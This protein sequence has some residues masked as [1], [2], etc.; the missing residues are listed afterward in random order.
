MMNTKITFMCHAMTSHIGKFLC[1]CSVI[2]AVGCTGN[3]TA[4][5]MVSAK[6]QLE[7]NDSQAAVIQLKNVLQKDPNLA[8]ARYLLGVTLLGLGDPV[9]AGV[10]LSK[11]QD[12]GFG[13]DKV[14]P[15]LAKSLF[16]QGQN[17]KI[18]VQYATTKLQLASAQADLLSIVANAYLALGKTKESQI[19][20]DEALRI[21]PGNIK[22][23]LLQIRKQAFLRDFDGANDRL[24]QLLASNPR[25]SEAWLVRGE[26]LLQSGKQEE[27]LAAYRKAIVFDNLNI[28]TH[29]A[30]MWILLSKKDMAAVDEQ[31]K[32][33]RATLP[34][35]PQIKFFAAMVSLEKGDIKSAY[36]Q[37]QLLLKMAPESLQALQLAGT[38]D[39]RRGANR[40]AEVN[41]T[42][43]LNISPGH[44]G[45]RLLLAQVNL[46]TG[47][48][49]KAIKALQL[50]VDAPEP[51]WEP[52]ALM[53][54]ALLMQGETAQ[55]ELY[56]M[57]AAKLN[58][59]DYRSRIAL[60]MGL[61]AKGKTEQGLS[62]LRAISALDR[63]ATADLAEINF[64]LRKKNVSSALKAI[65]NLAQKLPNSPMPVNLRGEIE[66][67]QGHKD[68][69][70]AAFTSALKIDP[71]YFPASAGIA[72]LDTAQGR[73]ELAIARFEKLSEAEPVN[74]R[75]VMALFELRVRT[76]AS[77]KDLSELLNKSI[78]SN[79]DEAGPRLALVNI[80]LAAGEKKLALAAVQDAVAAMPDNADLIEALARIQVIDGDSN[81]ALITYTKLA[82]QIPNSPKA[83]MGMA[84]IYL[85]RGNPSAA[86]Q[87]L[88][89]A[90]S[91]KSDFLPA[92]LGLVLAELAAGHGQEA[93]AVAKL[94]QTQ[95]AAET[96]G[97]ELEGNIQ[98]NLKNWA[99]AIKSYQF[100]LEKAPQT[101]TA[102]KVHK[103]YVAAG[104]AAEAKRFETEWMR[105]HG[106]DIQF[107]THLAD[108]AMVKSDFYL[109]K[110]QYEAIVKMQPENAVALN[111]I[112]WILN[113]DK[114]PIA[115]NYSLRA[116][117]LSPKNP[118]IMDTLADSY[119]NSGE[120]G[121]A[122]EIQKE[123]VALAPNAYDFRLSLARFYIAA[124][125]KRNAK[126]ELIWLEKL[127]EKL[128]NQEEIARLLS[129]LQ[130]D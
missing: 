93:V 69:A 128:P 112:A 94:V 77:R 13:A 45:I 81:Q 22:A 105:Q 40:L 80:L 24:D 53:G 97:Y 54:Q 78:K 111:N 86:V 102:V 122:I 130:F 99:A 26:V 92:Q 49:G 1:V 85:D 55:A 116:V 34:K 126:S 75:A 19:A 25:S 37:S 84:K 41:L 66:M 104:R 28:A 124:G 51:Q 14:V 31:L 90:L 11:A 38:V 125:E 6:R 18:I 44:G 52:N 118:A 72:A 15:L 2:F 35:S 58:P 129:S 43:A 113:K 16:A 23:S 29:S 103:A 5:L 127:G 82:A 60:A 68:Q 70:R 74:T 21:D 27:A 10:E 87:S 120:L 39:F 17:E 59:E 119:A 88:R 107:M 123:A 108:L 8:E 71:S 117:E 9:A 20:L 101:A 3:S 7:A 91:I 100:V 33:F 63:D 67:Q 65:D 76:G 61:M 46:R 48:T 32:F 96:I 95:H 50:L 98:T 62:N 73:P 110:R 42:K 114:N 47:E 57:R 36:E 12:Q 89:K 30:I 106:Q 4:D 83:H 115:L 56:F 109:A 79:P 121:K 64:H